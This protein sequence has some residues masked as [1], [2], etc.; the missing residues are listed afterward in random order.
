[1]QG[2][3][4]E[5]LQGERGGTVLREG[6]AGGRSRGSPVNTG[7]EREPPEDAPLDI[8]VLL[9]R[10]E[11]LDRK[12][13]DTRLP[14]SVIGRVVVTRVD[15]YSSTGVVVDSARPISVGARVSQFIN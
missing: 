6:R 10:L 2:E 7:R 14:V 13:E 11:E 9:E 1:M 15:D 4:G 12:Q 5:R 8:E 3:K